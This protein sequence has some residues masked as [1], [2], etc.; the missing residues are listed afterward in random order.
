MSYEK[1]R[2]NR[3]EIN[4]TVKGSY[5]QEVSSDN[6]ER[7]VLYDPTRVCNICEIGSG[8]N[9][10]REVREAAELAE[11][12]ASHRRWEVE[13]LVTG[14]EDRWESKQRAQLSIDGWSLPDEDSESASQDSDS[15]AGWEMI[16]S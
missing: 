5:G 11:I 8:H 16:D 4:G 7:Q 3:R 10:G 9:D 1:R 13:A 6:I 15:S 2:M 12:L 14:A